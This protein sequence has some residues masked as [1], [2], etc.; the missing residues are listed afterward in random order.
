MFFEQRWGGVL[1]VA[2]EPSTCPPGT[3]QSDQP[4]SVLV[5]VRCQ[6]NPSSRADRPFAADQRSDHCVFVTRGQLEGF[7]GIFGGH[8]AAS[9]RVDINDCNRAQLKPLEM[10]MADGDVKSAVGLVWDRVQPG[11]F[12]SGAEFKS[13]LDAHGIEISTSNLADCWWPEEG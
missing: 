8:P 13:F 4:T 11:K 6:L 12:A 3:T 5:Q 7:F 9:A 2:V 10:S 1:P